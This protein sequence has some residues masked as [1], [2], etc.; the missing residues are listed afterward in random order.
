M[1]VKDWV[2]VITGAGTGIG[3]AAAK[4]LAGQGASVVVN[5]SRSAEAAEE[6]AAACR[7]LGGRAVAMQGDVAEDADCRRIAADTVA[8]FG[9]I[10]GLMN[11]AG[12][13]RLVDQSDLDNLTA[14]DFAQIYRVNVIGA[15]QMT[16]AV[17]PQMKKQGRGSVVMTSSIAG[18]MGIGSSMAYA[19]SKGALNTLTLSLARNLAPEIRV[20][21]I[22]PGFVTGRWW[23]EKMDAEAYEKMVANVAAQTPLK[24]AGTP[25][26][27][28][29]SAV[30]LLAGAHNI[31]GEFL[32]TDSGMHLG[33]APLK[34]R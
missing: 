26:D 34:A 30:W 31:T 10:D 33:A 25:E 12:T 7:K 11:N 27:M 32:I 24:H 23:Q 16:R 21:G 19:A 29:E 15:F 9:R 17:V 28:A 20:N 8:E 4:R 2:V 14:D 22:C 1:D 13:T 5:Y 3:A 6:T 18:V